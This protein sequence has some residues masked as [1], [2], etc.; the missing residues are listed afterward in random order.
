[1]QFGWKVLI[2]VSLV[3]IMIVSTMRVLSNEKASRAAVLGFALGTV[4]VI[5]SVSMLFDRSKNKRIEE[6]SVI[7]Y[8]T[9]D[10]PI[11]ELPNKKMEQLNG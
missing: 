8:A 5:L 11:P 1:M 6:D 2:P 9:P 3:W 4:L 10:F 7:S